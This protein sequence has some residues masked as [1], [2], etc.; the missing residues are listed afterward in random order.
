M[1]LDAF[2][3]PTRGGDAQDLWP[4]WSWIA[5]PVLVAVVVAALWYPFC[6]PRPK[7]DVPTPTATPTVTRTVRVTLLPPT[8]A[9]TQAPSAVSEGTEPTRPVPAEQPT[10]TAPPAI[11]AETPVV[12]AP[13]TVVPTAG[14]TVGAEAAVKGTGRLGLN[15]R[16]G[17]GTTH[18]RIKTLTEGTIVE[19][20]G[21]PTEANNYTWLEVRDDAGITGWVVD[22]FLDLE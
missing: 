10:F 11:S 14:S 8:R 5:V 21:G 19:I 4:R 6:C 17:A 12:E 9:P 18:A 16:S 13:A 3:R 1:S 22:D 15:M 20:V 7:P 2:N